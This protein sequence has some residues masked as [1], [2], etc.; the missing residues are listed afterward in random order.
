[1]YKLAPTVEQDMSRLKKAL[2]FYA[3]SKPSLHIE[4]TYEMYLFFLFAWA[5]SVYIIFLI[6]INS[7]RKLTCTGTLLEQSDTYVKRWPSHRLFTWKYT[8]W[9]EQRNTFQ[10]KHYKT[11]TCI[12]HFH[13]IG[14]LKLYSFFLIVFFY[15]SIHFENKYFAAIILP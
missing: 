3:S 8:P 4:S 6:Y 1:M 2:R 10:L 11:C 14:F 15:I 5:K 7:S 12:C 13:I 9:C